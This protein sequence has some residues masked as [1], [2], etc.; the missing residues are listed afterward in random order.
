[1]AFRSAFLAA[2][3]LLGGVQSLS[4]EGM[5]AAPRRSTANVNPSGELALFTSSVY[6]WTTHKSS[7][8]WQVLDVASGNVTKAPFGS[9]VSE[10]VWVG[11]T[12]TSILYIN[13]TN[14]EVPGG[15]TLYTADLG[16]KNFTATL[17]ASLHA[18]FS[19]LK[20]AKT[21]SGIN[22]VVNALAYWNN[23]TA[24]NEEL[25]TTPFSTGQIYDNNYVRHW[26]TYVSQQRYAVFSGVLTASYGG[27]TLAGE[28]KNLLFGIEDFVTKPET[29]VQPFGDFGDYDL[30]PDGKKVAFLTKAPELPKANYTASYIYTVPH[31]GS[32]APVA[33]NGPGSKAPQTAQGASESPRWSPDSTRLAYAQQDNII[34]ES[35]R[36]KLYVATIEGNSTTVKSVAEDWDSSP[37]GITWSADGSNLWVTSEI[38]AS[39]RLFVIPADAPAS[40][41]PANIT[42]PQTSLSDFTVLLSGHALVSASASWTSRIFYIVSPTTT[43]ETKILFDAQTVDPEL[44]TV[45]QSR[46]SSIWYGPNENGD[47]IQA[48]V[49]YPLNFTTEKK[50]PVIFEIHGGPQSSQGDT[51]SVRW[52]MQLWAE[53][54]FVVVVPQFTGTPGYGQNFTDKITNNWGGT[55]Y[56]DIELLFEHLE[57]NVSYIDTDRAVAGGAS[58]GGFMTNWIQGHALGRK[59]KALVTHDGKVNQYGAYAT[60]EIYFIQHDQNGNLWEN[61][62]NYGLWDP[63]SHAKNFSTPHFIAHNDLDYRVVQ[64]E[65]LSLFNI[66]QTKG[67]PSRFLHFKDENHWTSNRENSLL[68]HRYIFNWLK[69]WV[70]ID[71]ELIQ[72]GVIKQ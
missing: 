33:V 38:H 46:S 34:Y 58:F 1:M 22:F 64:S 9:A 24:Y 19:G 20:A 41:K 49:Y 3:L 42:G 4:I 63:L 5:L 57:K 27:Y 65:G 54:G 12:N 6:N 35:D 47:L 8:T 2:S 45:S 72:E 52:N 15:V 13:S 14:D 21:E 50:W 26:D 18:P 56:R 59:F 16:Q 62:E 71:E 28:P 43:S 17:V 36:F 11:A 7:T 10:F 55:P 66:L 48:F 37:G 25:V 32:S 31:D 30:S 69:Y 29:P 39:N 70:A 60:D 51:W 23:G 68:W 44:T 67:V 61:R 53:Q 40:Y